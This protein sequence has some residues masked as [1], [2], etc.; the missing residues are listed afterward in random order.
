MDISITRI[1]GIAAPHSMEM[2][3][4]LPKRTWQPRRVGREQS[5]CGCRK[6]AESPVTGA[7]EM[8]PAHRCV[9]QGSQSKDSEG[10]VPISPPDCAWEPEGS[11]DRTAVSDDRGR[12]GSAR[13][14]APTRGPGRGR[15]TPNSNWRLSPGGCM[16]PEARTLRIVSN[17]PWAQDLLG[18]LGRKLT[19][20]TLRPSVT[21]Q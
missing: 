14:N 6:A 9:P 1:K 17:R 3:G 4:I 8:E 21:A 10:L 2:K 5:V 18:L 7:D 16:K 13:R 15:L 11:P 20:P 19:A 12:L